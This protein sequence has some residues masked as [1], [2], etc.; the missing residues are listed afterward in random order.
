[1]RDMELE[2]RHLR[3]VCAIAEAYSLTRAA[4]AL[5][6]TQPGLSTQL[7]R[8]ESMLGGVLFDRR[9]A[10]ATPTAFGE[11]VL[12]RAHAVLPGIDALLADTARAAR[13]LASPDRIRVGSV[14]APLIGH[15]VLAI[16]TLLPRAEVTSRCHYSPVTL[17]DDL[18][19]A[20]AWRRRSSATTRSRSCHRAT[21]SFSP[22]SSP[23]PS[24]PCCPRPTPWPVRRPCP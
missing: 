14:G 22:P 2:V 13:H 15:L 23:N 9:R 8:I 12:A 16:R 20:A 4:A 11:L 3:V 6:M 10:G 18:A 5:S 19:H 17:L 7:R 24:S 21:G 1:M